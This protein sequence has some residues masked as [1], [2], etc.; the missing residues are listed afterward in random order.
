[1]VALPARGIR[2]APDKTS[3]IIFTVASTTCMLALAYMLG[4]R[5]RHLRLNNISR[6]NFVRKLVVFMYIVGILFVA[7]MTIMANGR[8]VVTYADCHAA[9]IMC[10]AFYMGSKYLMYLFLVERAHVIR[11]PSTRRLSDK[12]WLCGMSIVNLGFGALSV[13]GFLWPVAQISE[14]DGKCRVGMLPRVTITMLA[15]DIVINIGFTVLFICLLWPLL[16]FHSKRSRPNATVSWFDHLLSRTPNIEIREN[17][18]VR[19]DVG[20]DRLLRVLRKLVLKTVVGAFL[21]MLPTTANLALLF[22]LGNH[23][24]G[25]LCST[26]CSLDVTWSVCIVH[27]LTVDHADLDGSIDLPAA[28]ATGKSVT[29]TTTTT[30]TDTEHNRLSRAS[31]CSARLQDAARPSFLEIPGQAP[32]AKSLTIVTASDGSEA[33][34]EQATPLGAVRKRTSISQSSLHQ[35]V[36]AEGSVE[37]EAGLLTPGPASRRPTGESLSFD[38]IERLSGQAERRI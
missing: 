5:A 16:S 21:I 20:N 37:S 36:S 25:W 26:I 6:M 31:N 8:G 32:L 4:S 15:F 28:N 29:N 27:W 38:H 7:T 22:K 24:Q 35:V 13:V 9:I 14:I 17:D 3:P 2:H 19:V 10:L 11:A 12:V 30:T 34:A 23:E 18:E 1:M 33:D